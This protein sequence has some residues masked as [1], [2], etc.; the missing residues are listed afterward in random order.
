MDQAVTSAATEDPA[1]RVQELIRHFLQGESVPG[2]ELEAKM[3]HT[4]L[5]D[6]ANKELLAAARELF[7]GDGWFA[8][9][10]APDDAEVVSED[11][12]LQALESAPSWRVRKPQDLPAPPPLV[13]ERPVPGTIVGSREIPE[14]GATEWTLSNGARVMVRPSTIEPDQ[15]LFQAISRGGFASEGLSALVPGTT[16]VPIAVRSG[17]G[18]LDN[19]DLGRVLNG[20]NFSLSPYL[21]RSY[22]GFTGRTVPADLE[23]FFAL[24]HERVVHPRLTDAALSSEKSERASY[25]S[26]RLSDPDEVADDALDHALYGDDPWRKPWTVED[27]ERMNLDRSKAIYATR[28]GNVGDWT[29][30]IAGAVDLE[31]LRP[32]VETWLAS[33]PGTPG[34]VEPAGDDGVR[35]MRGVKEVVVRAGIAPRARVRLV[36]SGP[37]SPSAEERV[38]LS[39]MVDVLSVELRRAL[40]EKE[41]GVYGVSA[42]PDIW[43]QPWA[44]YRVEVAFTCDPARVDDLVEKVRAVITAMRNAPLS[45]ATIADVRSARL[46]GFETDVVTNRWWISTMQHVVDDGDPGDL[47]A[48]YP[49]RVAALTPLAVQGAATRYLDPESY[50]LVKQLPAE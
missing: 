33:L 15:V 10:S 19:R 20:T 49:A 29:F 17:V 45:N 7:G 30:L 8:A 9:L 3:A 24:L 32:L 2:I 43:T 28:F 40:R 16:A 42:D 26:Q 37:W 48:T 13:S 34:F 39:G 25:L 35:P 14:L 27:L 46:E 12:L 23:T 31:Q 41:A 1:G 18:A 4:W 44:G 6:L 11:E 50:V 5:P 21:G 38:L 47:A 36:F 22:E